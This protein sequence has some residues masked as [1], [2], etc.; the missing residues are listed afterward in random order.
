MSNT[1]DSKKRWAIGL[2]QV[3]IIIGILISL[4]LAV[5]L[6]AKARTGRTITA[7]EARLDRLVEAERE[8]GKQLEVTLA[9]VLSDDYVADYARNEGGMTLPGEVRVVP[10]LHPPPLTPTPMPTPL[11]IVPIPDDPW[12]AWWMLFFDSLPPGK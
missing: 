11:P 9:Y 12:E 3:L 10:M 5:D 7:S 1:L 6:T 4:G 8:R 2:P